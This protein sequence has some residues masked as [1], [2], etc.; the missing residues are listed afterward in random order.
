[1]VQVK[2]YRKVTAF[3]ASLLDLDPVLEMS[4]QLIYFRLVRKYMARL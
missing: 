2:V 1:V 3:K 4:A